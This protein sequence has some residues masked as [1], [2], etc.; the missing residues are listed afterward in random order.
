[1]TISRPS[2]VFS[3][4][5]IQCL[6][7]FTLNLVY[8]LSCFKQEGLTPVFNSLFTEYFEYFAPDFTL[9]PDVSTKIENQ[10][11]RQYLE[12]IR[13]SVAENLRVLPHAPSVQMQQVR[14]ELLS[15]SCI[16]L[17][18]TL[19]M[20]LDSMSCMEPDY[21]DKVEHQCVVL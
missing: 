11:S 21:M 7:C 6:L 16:E 14:F 10:N 8:W 12:Q 2:R 4:Y 17:D 3:L 13:V 20:E 5:L 15:L 19:C 18:S 9:H 1:M